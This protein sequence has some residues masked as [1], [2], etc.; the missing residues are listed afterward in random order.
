MVTQDDTHLDDAARKVLQVL[1]HGRANVHHVCQQSGL[2]EAAAEQVLAGLGTEGLATQVD[3]RLYSIT[4]E[5]IKA[6]DREYPDEAGFLQDASVIHDAP[7]VKT[8]RLRGD[9]G[10]AEVQ[11]DET[12]V[13]MLAD[14]LQEVLAD[15]HEEHPAVEALEKLAATQ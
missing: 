8:V 1:A 14:A 13:T 7:A 11:V 4:P 10:L 9:R 15:T 5:G 12:S 3:R 2:G 6:L